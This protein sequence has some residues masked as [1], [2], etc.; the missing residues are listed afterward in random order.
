VVN[1]GFSPLAGRF[2]IPYSIC[3]YAIIPYSIMI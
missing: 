3:T 1:S 2:L